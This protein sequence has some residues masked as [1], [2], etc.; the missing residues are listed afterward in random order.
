[1]AEG[2][3]ISEAITGGKCGPGTRDPGVGANARYLATA[4]F[5]QEVVRYPSTFNL[6]QGVVI[7]TMW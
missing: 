4:N 1:V 2:T 6:A 3:R 5:G 7:F